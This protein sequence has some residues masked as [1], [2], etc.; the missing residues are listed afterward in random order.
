MGTEIYN[1][2]S[3]QK[4]VSDDISE[5]DLNNVS[6]GKNEYH[7]ARC[8]E[9]GCGWTDGAPTAEGLQYKINLHTSA[10]GHSNIIHD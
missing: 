9:P 1:S 6:G 4:N 10:T 2:G 3:Q 8:K 7:V 5:M